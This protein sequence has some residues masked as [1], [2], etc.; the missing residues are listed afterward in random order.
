MSL[1]PEPCTMRVPGCRPRADGL[2]FGHRFKDQGFGI[3]FREVLG[4]GFRPCL[5]L[6]VQDLGLGIY[7]A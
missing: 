5:G 4:L 7:R 1:G 2:G 3:G 6:G